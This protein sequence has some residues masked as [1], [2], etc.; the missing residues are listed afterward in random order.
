SSELIRSVHSRFVADARISL[1][2]NRDASHSVSLQEHLAVHAIPAQ[3]N[4]TPAFFMHPVLHLVEHFASPILR[5]HGNDEHAITLERQRAVMQLRLSI[6][7]VVK[8]LSF[9]PTEQPPCRR[10]LSTLQPSLNGIRD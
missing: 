7:V 1:V 9:Q 3:I 10:S 5:M 4:E 2:L 8:L 6:V